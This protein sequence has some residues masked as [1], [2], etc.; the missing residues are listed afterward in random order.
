M[1]ALPL[2]PDPPALYSITCLLT[3][4]VPATPNILQFPEQILVLRASFT[5]LPK[6]SSLSGM[7]FPRFST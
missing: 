2:G 1:E 4:Y 7:P 5:T 6:L 3:H